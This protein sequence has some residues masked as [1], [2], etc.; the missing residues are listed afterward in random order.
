MSKHFERA[1][2]DLKRKILSLSGAVEESLWRAVQSVKQSDGALAAEVIAKDDAIDRAEVEVEEECLKILALY[3]PVAADLRFLIAALK[4]NNDLERIG[5]LAVNIAKK[6]RKLIGLDTAPAPV[7]IHDIAAT[8]QKMLRDSLDA[9]VSL[10]SALARK[11]L[12]SDDEVD[13]LNNE[14]RRR[15]KDEIRRTPERLD[16]LLLWLNICRHIERV[17]DQAANIAEYV[18][19]LVDGDIVRHR[20]PENG[21][22]AQE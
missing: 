19:Y 20:P 11:V 5:D 22:G 6:S 16:A 13:R 10:N 14:L 4:I 1:I 9:L 17:A 15:L 18:I 21:A 3:Q 7:D 8:A 12:A 2:E